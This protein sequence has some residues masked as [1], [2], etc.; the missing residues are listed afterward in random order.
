MIISFSIEKVAFFSFMIAPASYKSDTA[1]RTCSVWSLGECKKDDDVV[2]I[3]QGKLRFNWGQNDAHRAMIGSW[4]VLKREGISTK[5]HC[6]WWDLSAVSSQLVSSF[7][8]F[9]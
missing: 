6:P 9:K 8:T 2:E 5:Q 3:Y 4:C 7:S 1:L